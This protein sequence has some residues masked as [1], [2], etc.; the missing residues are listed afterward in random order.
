MTKLW[1]MFSSLGGTCSLGFIIRSSIAKPFGGTLHSLKMCEK[2]VFDYYCK[3]TYKFE[4][5]HRRCGLCWRKRQSVFEAS[6]SIERI[7]QSGA[8]LE[9]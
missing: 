1:A 5:I 8:D 4:S 9:N 6:H 7:R 2:L 3:L